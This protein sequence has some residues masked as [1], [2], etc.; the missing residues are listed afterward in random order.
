MTFL[1]LDALTFFE[2]APLDALLLSPDLR[3]RFEL[4]AFTPLLEEAIVFLLLF[5]PVL[6]FFLP[7]LLDKPSSLQTSL[8]RHDRQTLFFLLGQGRVF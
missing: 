1:D 6:L 5:L 2:G 8:Q 3:L 4:E 7:L